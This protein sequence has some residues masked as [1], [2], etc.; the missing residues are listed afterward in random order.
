MREL[1]SQIEFD[2]TPDEVWEVLQDLARHAEWNPFITKIDGELHPGAKLDVRL[3]PEGE[4]GIDASDGPGCRAG[5]RAPLAR[6]PA[7]A[8]GV[9]R[10]APIPDRGVGARPRAIHPERALR[11]ILLP[12][13]WKKLRDGGT[14]KGFRAMNEALARRVGELHPRAI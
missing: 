3:E 13:F 4:R 12:L 7:R 11:G 8:G 14:A 9:R 1:S 6:S 5:P 2:A 10:R